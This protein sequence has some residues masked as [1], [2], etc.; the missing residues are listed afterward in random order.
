MYRLIALAFFPEAKFI[1]AAFGIGIVGLGVAIPAAP[2]GIG[3][4]Q[5]SI[6]WVFTL[7]GADES[8]ALAYSILVHSIYLAITSAIG[9]IGLNLDGE[10]LLDVYDQIRSRFAR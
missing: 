8:I 10:S 6:V 2:G 1:W 7:F 4:V 3:V 9:I 5:A